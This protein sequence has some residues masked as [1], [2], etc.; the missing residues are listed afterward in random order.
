MSKLLRTLFLFALPFTTLQTEV[1]PGT[2]T[3][4]V[5]FGTLPLC[6]QSCGPLFD[7]EYGC[8]PPVKTSVDTNCFCTDPRVKAVGQAGPGNTCAAACTVAADLSAVQTWFNSLC[9]AKGATPATTV[10]GGGGSPTTTGAGSTGTDTSGNSGNSAGDGNT[11]TAPK[12]QSW[13]VFSHVYQ[14]SIPRIIS[15]DINR[16]ATHYKYV[17]MIVIIVLAIVGGWVAAVFFRR[18]YLRKRELNYEMR[19]PTAPWVTG[20]TGPTGPYGAGGFGDGAAGKEAAM[21]TTPMTAAQVQK[22]KK[23]W[24]VGAR[25]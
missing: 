23:K 2:N 16:I 5:P 9:S 20:H 7:V 6:A 18:R 22:E 19:P 11:G 17:I 21:M 25:T 1:K 10:A 8:V 3:D 12:N 4:I 24:I 14:S 15:T 13:W